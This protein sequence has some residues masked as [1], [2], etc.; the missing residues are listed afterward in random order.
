MREP[1][2]WWVKRTGT[3]NFAVVCLLLFILWGDAPWLGV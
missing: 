2:P 1:T 3:V